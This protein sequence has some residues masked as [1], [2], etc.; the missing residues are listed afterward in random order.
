MSKVLHQHCTYAVLGCFRHCGQPYRCG[1]GDQNYRDSSSAAT[2]PSLL[3][4]HV[5]RISPLTKGANLEMKHCQSN[6][7]KIKFSACSSLSSL[8]GGMLVFMRLCILLSLYISADLLLGTQKWRL[9]FLLA[10]G[11]A[12]LANMLYFFF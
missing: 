4:C 10:S 9:L 5:L 7:C 11:H 1:M 2:T 12:T 6:A 8:H 3:Q